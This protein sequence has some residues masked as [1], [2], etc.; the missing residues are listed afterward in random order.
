M[1]RSL[2]L[3]LFALTAWRAAELPAEAFE[4]QSNGGASQNEDAFSAYQATLDQAATNLLKTEPGVPPE[5]AQTAAPQ[6]PSTR[7]SAREMIRL[8]QFA[9]R[10]WK[11]R[12]AD[13][14]SAVQRMRQLQPELEGIL[15]NEG[16]PAE[17]IAVVLIESAGRPAALSPRE[18]RGLWQFIPATAR[19]YGLAVTPLRDDR[20]DIARSTHAAARYLRDLYLQ[21]G[22]S[23]AA[24]D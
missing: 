17:L 13:F 24:G 1:R 18:A 20:L 9:R 22:A 23:R 12:E 14:L 7:D 19:R 10:Y 11:G 2:I 8:N 21:F 16:V 3:V 4:P 6:Q 5:R 15:R